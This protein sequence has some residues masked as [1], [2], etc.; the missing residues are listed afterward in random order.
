[1]RPAAPLRGWT[2]LVAEEIGGFAGMRLQR[3]VAMGA[4]R[5][6]EGADDRRSAAAG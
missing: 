1:M 6:P 3:A 4:V 5:L 2:H